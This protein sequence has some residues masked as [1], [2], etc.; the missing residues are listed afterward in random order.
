VHSSRSL[1][2]RGRSAPGLSRRSSSLS[3]RGRSR[4]WLCRPVALVA[5]V[6]LCCGLLAGCGAQAPR[7]AAGALSTAVRLLNQARAVHMS[8]STVGKPLPK[9]TTAVSGGGDFLRPDSF[10][11]SFLVSYGGFSFSIPIIVV[12]GVIYIRLPLEKSFIKTSLAKYQFPNPASLFDPSKGLPAVFLATRDL[13]YG[14]AVEVG[15]T[16]LWSLNGT[17]PDRQVASVLGTVS[18]SGEVRVSYE[19][20]PSSGRLEGVSLT[21]PFFSSRAHNTVTITL[22]HYDEVI[23]VSA[24]K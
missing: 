4:L 16:S 5:L 14:G 2:L 23:T 6:V 18:T 8:Y 24:P 10:S 1:S 15:S 9:D 11:G 3:L 17:L 12:N 21:G 13:N 20:Y 19:I 22:S 7:S